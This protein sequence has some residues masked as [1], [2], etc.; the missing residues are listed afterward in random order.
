LKFNKKIRSQNLYINNKNMKLIN[1]TSSIFMMSLLYSLVT[2]AHFGSKGPFGGSVKTLTPVGAA[3]YL[4]SEEGG[5]YY[6][7]TSSATAWTYVNYTGLTSGK[8]NAVSG[9]GTKVIAATADHGI[10]YSVDKG[11]TWK[12]SN[13]P[14]EGINT[15]VGL[16]ANVVAGTENN[17]IY[18]SVDTGK[19]WSATA[20][21]NGKIKVLAVDGTTL[22]AGSDQGVS[23][24]N[25]GGATWTSLNSGLTTTE[26]MSLS[27]SNGTIYAGTNNGVFSTN[28]NNVSWNTTAGLGNTTVNGLFSYGGITYAAT[29]GGVYSI[30]DGN[31]SWDVANSGYTGIVTSVAVFANKLF[32]GSPDGIYRSNS[33]SVVN[34]SAFNQGFNNLDA[35]TV[36]NNGPLVIAAT[37]KGLFVSRDLAA[38]YARANSGLTDSLHVVGL[39]FSGAKLYAATKNGGVFATADTGKTWTSANVGLLNLSIKSIV[40]GTHALVAV[41]NDGTVYSSPLGNISWTAGTGMPSVVP[42]ALAT[43]GTNFFLGTLGNGIYTSNNATNWTAF[44]TGLT[45]LNITSLAVKGIWV[46]AGTSGAGVFR[47]SVTGTTWEA[48]NSGLPSLYITALA[49][50]DK[51]IA[52]GFKGGVHSTSNNGTTWESLN[53]IQYLPQYAE[54]NAISFGST[55]TG[56]TRIFVSTPKNALYSNGLGEL[57]VSTITGLFDFKDNNSANSSDVQIFPNPNN[58]TF[59]LQYAAGLN[60]MEVVLTDFTGRPVKTLTDNFEGQIHQEAVPG[61]YFVHVKSSKGLIVKKILIE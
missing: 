39:T 18:V 30:A 50:N 38:N 4:G 49:A 20:S 55:S 25:D 2:L 9:I 34:W 19:T 40:A 17:G 53:V 36:Y 59:S 11:V 10:F 23:A 3:L 12:A 43:D 57:A 42:T 48:A 1:K 33:I 45:N 24:S 35:Y 41:G 32:L 5:V 37:N 21:P 29:N 22:Y 47:S 54:V 44:N 27:V 58:G 28:T 26:I 16:G 13:L 46:F 8:I 6:L 60:P 52:A 15:L 31:S 14:G 51:W 56:S 61:I 7:P